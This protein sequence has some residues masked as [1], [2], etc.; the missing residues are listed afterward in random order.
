VSERILYAIVED[1]EGNIG[2]S[3]KLDIVITEYP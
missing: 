2:E 1:S 3:E